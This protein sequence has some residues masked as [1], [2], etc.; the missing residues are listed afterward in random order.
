MILG[1]NYLH[2]Y[3]RNVIYCSLSFDFRFNGLKLWQFEQLC[4]YPVNQLLMFDVVLLTSN[5]TAY[6]NKKINFPNYD[7]H[8]CVY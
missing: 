1:H 2:M 6:V 7:F 3:I 8:M 4:Y 5:S